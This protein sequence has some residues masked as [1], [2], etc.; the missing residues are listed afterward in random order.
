[1]QIVTDRAA[2]FS[3]D[4]LKGLKINFAPLI[5]T[6]DGIS[7]RSGEDIQPEDF[8]RL[9]EQ[10]ND[11]P[12][13]SQPSAGD[14]A[15]L[16][17]KLAVDDPEILSIHISSGLSGTLSAAQAGAQMVPEARVHFFDTKT[18]SCPEAW[19]VEA[20]AI[21]LQAGKSLDEIIN[22][23]EKLRDQV[24][25]MFTLT[26]LKYLVHGGR[27]SHMKGLLASLLNIKPIIGVGKEDG[28]YISFGQELTLK[29]AMNKMVEQVSEWCVPGS[30]IRVQLLHGNNLTGT[31]YL[32]E[33][34]VQIYNVIWTP[35][36][37]IGPVLGAHT[38][39]GLVGMAV[40]PANLFT[41]KS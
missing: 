7:Y 41:E 16:Y 14:F 23:L 35:T 4:Q 17:R 26:T 10:S 38:G 24:Q 2:D 21:G 8:Y 25:G 13:T 36:T 11:Y 1:M 22:Y 30:T 18:L 27:I 31:D 39:S 19:I 5:L 32:K 40:A 37:A 34:L 9:L 28:K 3:S 6:L 33:K 15:D 29:R 20:A 12:T